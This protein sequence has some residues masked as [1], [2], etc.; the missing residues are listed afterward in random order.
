MSK[1]EKFDMVNRFGYDPGEFYDEA[2]EKQRKL[3]QE[4]RQVADNI[5]EAFKTTVTGGGAGTKSKKADSAKEESL[6]GAAL[7]S[8]FGGEDK[9]TSEDLK[10]K[11]KQTRSK[12]SELRSQGRFAEAKKLQGTEFSQRIGIRDLRSMERAGTVGED[13]KK[14]S[15]IQK[16]LE[17]IEKELTA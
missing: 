1:Q 2:I 16:S 4:S 14:L 17:I 6:L 8:G 10:E 12:V 15:A 13:S 7:S 11:L 9:L 5:S 3:L